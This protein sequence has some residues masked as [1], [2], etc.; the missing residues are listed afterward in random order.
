MQSACC[1]KHPDPGLF[2]RTCPQQLI[3]NE[4]LPHDGNAHA[5]H[6]DGS[7]AR[8]LA[9][10]RKSFHIF[11]L[12]SHIMES[13]KKG[14]ESDRGAGGAAGPVVSDSTTPLLV[15]EVRQVN[16]LR[17]VLLDSL[18]GLSPLTTSDTVVG[19]RNNS[20]DSEDDQ[21]TTETR[22]G[23]AMVQWALQTVGF[24]QEEMS[25]VFRLLQVIQTLE[26]LDF[27]DSLATRPDS[28]AKTHR[29]QES[30]ERMHLLRK[31]HVRCEV[32]V[33]KIV[34]APEITDF[35]TPYHR[36]DTST[37]MI[38]KEYGLSC[39]HCLLRYSSHRPPNESVCTALNVR[40]GY[41]LISTGASLCRLQN[42]SNIKATGLC[43]SVHHRSFLFRVL[44]K[45]QLSWRYLLLC[46]KTA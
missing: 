1:S 10:E 44:T 32:S 3:F 40:Q 12:L 26:D 37:M 35:A 13:Q 18:G 24:T 45:L 20:L 34:A 25:Y 29:L 2:P 23:S 30:A 38:H 21:W 15:D 14:A 43:P 8:P 28:H 19:D 9:G 31:P 42:M 6:L 5:L 4:M 41:R 46:L 39:Q 27:C 16:W 7:L 17:K 22:S 36:S 11:E 33:E